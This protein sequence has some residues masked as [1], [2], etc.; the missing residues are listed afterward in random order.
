MTALNRN[1]LD[2]SQFPK[3]HIWAAPG[4]ISHVKFD[5]PYTMSLAIKKKISLSAVLR[6]LL[7]IAN[8]TMKTEVHV[9]ITFHKTGNVGITQHCS[10]FLITTRVLISP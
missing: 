2:T 3:A 7:G 5:I 9:N 10:G 1:Q 6:P 8:L 4:E